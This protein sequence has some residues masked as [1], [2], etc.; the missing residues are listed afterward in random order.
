MYLTN[1]FDESSNVVNVFIFYCLVT[2]FYHFLLISW[3]YFMDQFRFLG[4]SAFFSVLVFILI[5]E[6][7][8]FS[9][10]NRYLSKK[11]QQ[12]LGERH[13]K[14]PA[15]KTRF[16]DLT[17]GGFVLSSGLVGYF[18]FSIL[19]GAGLFDEHEETFM[20]SA[21]LTCLTVWPLLLHFGSQ[22]AL[23]MLLGVKPASGDYTPLAELLLG[24]VQLA[25]AGAWLGAFV[26]PLDW[27]RPWQAWPIPCS[28][29]ALLGHAAAHLL[30]LGAFA[31][32]RVIKF[33]TNSHNRPGKK[34]K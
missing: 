4:K 24:S 14:I 9:I 8:K 2:V 1:N 3:L 20:L 13:K 29:G 30:A 28:T 19:F 23:G 10:A 7:L 22:G 27:D 34:I 33:I 31:G 32:P 21:L 15:N 6:T 17:R 25:V 12:G 5:A 18:A 26:L 16:R 11:E